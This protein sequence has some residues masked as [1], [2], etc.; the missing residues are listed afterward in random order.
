M[1]LSQTKIRQEIYKNLT[2]CELFNTGP[3]EGSLG[4]DSLFG[5]NV[6]HYAK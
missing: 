1:I 5:T 3:K 2:L 4:L 6:T